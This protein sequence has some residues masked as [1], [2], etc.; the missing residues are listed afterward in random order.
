MLH[1]LFEHSFD[2]NLQPGNLTEYD[3]CD[4]IPV[5]P[6]IAVCEDIPDAGNVIPIYFG[7]LLF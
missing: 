3:I 2:L 4:N 7:M 1:D 6:E 5:N